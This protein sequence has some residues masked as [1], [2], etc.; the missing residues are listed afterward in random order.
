MSA[1]PLRT[2]D[3]SQIQKAL[4]ALRTQHVTAASLME[5]DL[6]RATLAGLLLTL[7][8]G[9]EL[10]S[11]KQPE[12]K[13]VPFHSEVLEGGICYVRLG[14]LRTENLAQLDAALGTFGKKKT[15]GMVLDL[16]ST[17]ES[18]DF[19]IAAEAAGRFTAAGSPLFTLQAREESG[20]KTFSSATPLHRGVL[21]VLVDSSTRGAPEALAAA[22]RGHAG[23]M[24]VGTVTGG[25]AV[26]FAEMALGGGQTLR[27]AVAEARVE[28]LPALYPAGLTP[29]LVVPQDPEVKEALAKTEPTGSIAPFVF[30]QGREQLNEAALMAGTNPEIGEGSRPFEEPRLID[31][32][33]QRAVDLVTAIGLVRPG[34]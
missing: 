13:S 25:R 27:F 10:T 1:D 18:Q 6:E 20:T 2:L 34:N 15:T 17:P 30:E 16:R 28:G 31:R 29:D 12:P 21:V 14:S 5:T 19:A 4:S 22:L 32:P 26:E 7:Q 9:A 3:A 11:G 33:L 8:P 23:A 24:L